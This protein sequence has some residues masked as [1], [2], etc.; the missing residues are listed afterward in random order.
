VMA[1]CVWLLPDEAVVGEVGANSG[2]ACSRPSSE[3]RE[4]IGFCL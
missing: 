3:A 4:F 1:L 2:A